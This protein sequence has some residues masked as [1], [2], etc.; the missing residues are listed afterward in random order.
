MKVTRRLPYIE[1]NKGGYGRFRGVEIAIGKL[2]AFRCEV[3]IYKRE[4]GFGGYANVV[5]MG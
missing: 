5:R 4:S 2:N 3:H 1:V